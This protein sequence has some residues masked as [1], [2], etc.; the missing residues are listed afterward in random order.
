MAAFFGTSV[1]VIGGAAYLTGQAVASTWRPARH[2]VLYCLLLA[3]FDRFLVWSLFHGQLLSPAG[4]LLDAAVI[5]C[6]AFVGFRV[7][8]VACMVGQYPWLYERAGLW[9]YKAKAPAET[10]AGDR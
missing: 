2:L 3:L 10:G 9:A 4:F 7:T 8:H 6:F 1:L 5:A